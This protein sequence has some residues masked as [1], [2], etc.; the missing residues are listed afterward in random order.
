[1]NIGI[2]GYGVVGGTTGQVFERVHEVW[3]YDKYKEPYCAREHLLTLARQ[4]EV[5]FIC[6]DTPMKRSG[7][8]DCSSIRNSLDDLEEALREIGRD[9]SEVLVVIR[10]TAVSGTAEG[11][12]EDYPFRIAVNPEFL[13]ERNALADMQ[14]TKYVVIGT[15]EPQSADTLRRIYLAVFPEVRIHNLSRQTAEMVKYSAN[16]MLAGQIMLANELYQICQHCDVSWN[17]IKNIILNDPR[18]GR[19]IAVPGTDGALGFGGKCLPK[20]VNAMIHHANEMGY[21]PDLLR[22]VWRSNLRVRQDHDWE[23]IPGAVSR[24][25]EKVRK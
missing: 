18:I 23:Q 11:L 22:E 4:A 21:S 6:V 13:T 7:Q 8:I 24:R 16:V 20:D 10:S 19:N 2:I 3:P 15:N 5:V 9:P 25:P 14:N 17:V 12:A 1:M